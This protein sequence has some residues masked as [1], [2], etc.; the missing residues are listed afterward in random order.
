MKNSNYG[1]YNGKEVLKRFLEKLLYQ[2]G[3]GR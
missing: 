1:K 3:F 2:G